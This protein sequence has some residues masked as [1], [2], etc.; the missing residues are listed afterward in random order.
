MRNRAQEEARQHSRQLVLHLREGD[1]SNPEF[2][3]TAEP[4]N[5][6]CPYVSELGR[7]ERKLMKFDDTASRGMDYSVNEEE[8]ITFYDN[9]AVGSVVA[10]VADPQ[11]VG[12]EHNEYAKRLKTNG[13]TMDEVAHGS[14]SF[15]IA[16][17]TKNPKARGSDKAGKVLFYDI[18]VV[19]FEQTGDYQSHY[20]AQIAPDKET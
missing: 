13:P 12:P 19:W 16:Q 9:L 2:D 6:R 10:V 11:E 7:W 1:W 5:A 20:T 15:W 18:N 17:V 8:R 3:P 14:V 4:A